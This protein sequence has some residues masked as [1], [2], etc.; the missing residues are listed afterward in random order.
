MA[1]KKHP[2]ERCICHQRKAL[3][4][5]LVFWRELTFVEADNQS[6]CCRIGAVEGSLEGWLADDSTKYSIIEA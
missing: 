4:G 1:P 2:T 3:S 6:Q 5:M